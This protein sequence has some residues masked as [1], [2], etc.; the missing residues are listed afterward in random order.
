[1]LTPTEEFLMEFLDRA[2]WTR[3]IRGD[4]KT[5][6]SPYGTNLSSVPR[7]RWEKVLLEQFIKVLKEGN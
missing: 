7:D 5:W 1:M 6:D 2:F 3:A 4:T